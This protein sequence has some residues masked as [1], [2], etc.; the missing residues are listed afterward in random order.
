MIIDYSGRTD[1]ASII[2]IKN[3]K[4][5]IT[6]GKTKINTVKLLGEVANTG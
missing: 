1:Q 3:D 2:Y 4:I 6:Y 5:I